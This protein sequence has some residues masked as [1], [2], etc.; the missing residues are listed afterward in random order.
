MSDYVQPSI[1][2]AIKSALLTCRFGR[3]TPIYYPRSVLGL[4]IVCLSVLIDRQMN[5]H[6]YYL[7]A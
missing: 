2:A 7:V 1:R 6:L 4:S 3:Y 5:I